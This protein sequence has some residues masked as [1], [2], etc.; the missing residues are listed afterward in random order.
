M[1]TAIGAALALSAL[2]LCRHHLWLPL[3]FI[4]LICCGTTRRQRFESYRNIALWREC[5][6]RQCRIDTQYSNMN[7]LTQ[8]S[9]LNNCIFH[10]DFRFIWISSKREKMWRKERVARE[11]DIVCYFHSLVCHQYYNFVQFS[12][13][14]TCT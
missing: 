7:I 11:K 8:Y 12:Y 10:S 5:H 2:H 4:G 3:F 6:V 14:R 1:I 13:N 9:I